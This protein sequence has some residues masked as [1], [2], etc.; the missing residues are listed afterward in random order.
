MRGWVHPLCDIPSGCCSFTG[1]WTVHPPPPNGAESLEAPKAPK[2]ISDWTKARKKMW[3]TLV[4]GVWWVGGSRGGG[5]APPSGADLL[6]GALHTGLRFMTTAG[7]QRITGS[8]CRSAANSRQPTIND[9]GRQRPLDEHNPATLHLHLSSVQKMA[10]KHVPVRVLRYESH[11][12]NAHYTRPGE[13]LYASYCAIPN[14]FLISGG[15]ETHFLGQDPPSSL[16]TLEKPGIPIPL[17]AF[18]AHQK[19]PLL[20]PPKCALTTP[21]K[22]LHFTTARPATPPHQRYS[23]RSG[24]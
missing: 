20:V 11:S 7:P 13:Q 2:K 22:Q 15:I 17:A 5:G 19:S 24:G 9:C 6:K 1:P 14:C 23:S 8:G 21:P 10:K 4:R 18:P 12:L 16:S 3:P